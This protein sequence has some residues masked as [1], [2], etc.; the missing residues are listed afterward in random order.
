MGFRWECQWTSLFFL[1]QPH[2]ITT[3]PFWFSLFIY[4]IDLLIMGGKNLAFFM[5]A[6]A[7]VLVLTFARIIFLNMGSFIC[8]CVHSCVGICVRV[9][10]SK[11]NLLL[12]VFSSCHD[13][14]PWLSWRLNLGHQALWQVPLPSK[15]SG[16]PLSVFY[17]WQRVELLYGLPSDGLSHLYIV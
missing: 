8:F 14:H 15:P 1:I 12:S 10:I 2:C 7:Q 6:S 11:D 17:N 16:W 4:F 13:H 9:Y 3:P 5:A